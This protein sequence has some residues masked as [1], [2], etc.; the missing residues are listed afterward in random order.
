MFFFSFILFLKAKNT[1]M[2]TKIIYVTQT[3]LNKPFPSSG[4]TLS[5]MRT[6]IEMYHLSELN[7]GKRFSEIWKAEPFSVN[8]FQIE[9]HVLKSFHT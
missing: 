5:F 4:E 2:V 1:M 3:S 9:K 7:S 8:I 6:P